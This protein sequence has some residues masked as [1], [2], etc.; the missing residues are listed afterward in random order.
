MIPT[1]HPFCFREQDA[2]TWHIGWEIY[3]YNHGWDSFKSKCGLFFT[4]RQEYMLEV[5]ELDNNFEEF[6][7]DHTICDDCLPGYESIREIE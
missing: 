1:E 7:K 6:R 5:W 4:P 2:D 3:E